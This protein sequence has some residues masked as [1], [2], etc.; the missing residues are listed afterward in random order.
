MQRGTTQIAV[1]E[2]NVID[3]VSRHA[4]GQIRRDKALSFRRHTAGDKNR[5]Q[6]SLRVSL[7][8]VRAEA[9]KLLDACAAVCEGRKGSDT[10]LPRMLRNVFQNQF[11]LDERRLLRNG[12]DCQLG[13][14]LV[15]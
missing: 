15:F 1:D 6:W 13:S 11:G 8:D 5:L 9:A 2:Q 10:W 12:G 3:T 4:H 14:L 7:V